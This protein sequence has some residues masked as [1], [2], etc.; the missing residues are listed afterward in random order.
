[1]PRLTVE[2]P[3]ALGLEEAT[4]RLKTR[5]A[6]ARAE[7]QDRVSNFR[8]EWSDHTFSFAFQA[9]GMGVSG[10]VAVAAE[11]VKLHV[12]LPL[13]A[14]FFKGAIEDRLRREVGEL[15]AARTGAG[16]AR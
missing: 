15:L 5:F 9:M 4:Q 12:D 16:G 1:M 7:H 8:E 3:H 6:A 10:A 11:K 13:A 14:T 2:V